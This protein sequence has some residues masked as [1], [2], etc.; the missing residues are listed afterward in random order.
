MQHA[1]NIQS[2][3]SMKVKILYRYQRFIPDRLGNLLHTNKV[4]CASPNDFNDPWD[5]RPCF[6]EGQLEDPEVLEQHIRW[7]EQADRKHYPKTEDQHRQMAESLRRNPHRVR[8]MVNEVSAGIGSAIDQRYGVC[9]FTTKVDSTLM[10]SHYADHHHGICLEFGTDNDVVCAALKVEYCDE[11]PFLDLSDDGA[12][13]NLLPLIS[14]SSDWAYE[15]EYRLIAQEQN[16]ALGSG[17]LMMDDHLLELPP[18]AIKSVIAGCS[19]P[20]HI[21]SELREIVA[22][23]GNTVN[24]KKAVRI[25]DH[26]RVKIE[27][28]I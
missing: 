5:C 25:R 16:V 26:Y 6:N 15:D 17:S 21:R 19:M 18:C 4:Y 14:K 20:E 10:W 22:Q 27:P 8:E 2:A 24:L 13:H 1:M 12:E 11:Y 28:G 9:C 23:T 3:A 7:F